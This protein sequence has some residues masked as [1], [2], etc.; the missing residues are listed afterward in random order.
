MC[1]RCY[2]VGTVGTCP[3]G[4]EHC[5]DKGPFHFCCGMHSV[6][7]NSCGKAS[8]T[9]HWGSTDPGTPSAFICGVYKGSAGIFYIRKNYVNF[10]VP[11]LFFLCPLCSYPTLSPWTQLDSFVVL[12][13]SS[14]LDIFPPLFKLQKVPYLMGECWVEWT[15]LVSVE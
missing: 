3:S 9:V 1:A 15:S 8:C 7:L 2:I 4:T 6:Y 13:L 11:I 5:R 12:S 14:W 10:W